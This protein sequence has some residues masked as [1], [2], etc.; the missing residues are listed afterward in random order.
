M[1]G[2][3]SRLPISFRPPAFLVGLA[4]ALAVGSTAAAHPFGVARQG[5][6]AIAAITSLTPEQAHE[7]VANRTDATA[8]IDTGKAALAFASGGVS[9]RGALMLTSL[10]SLDAE[11]AAVLADYDEG[12]LFLD[13]LRELTPELIRALGDLRK[14]SLKGV[15]SLSPEAAAALL[16]SFRGGDV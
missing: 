15:T 14:R 8:R 11:T 13:G 12:P 2:V 16:E 1:S 9:L 6:D 3:S 10:E 5:G 7:L 4:L